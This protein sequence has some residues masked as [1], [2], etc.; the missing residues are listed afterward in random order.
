MIPPS[1]PRFAMRVE[2]AKKDRADG[3]PIPID[4]PKSMK[5]IK[6]V[7]RLLFG[8]VD[9]GAVMIAPK[10]IHRAR[11]FFL[12]L[13]K[14]HAPR[15]AVAAIA[16]KKAPYNEILVKY[17]RLFR[18]SVNR[19][20]IRVYQIRL[21]ATIINAGANSRHSIPLGMFIRPAYFCLVY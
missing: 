10:S 18:G 7:N 6:F 11:P 19:K 15:K 1:L 8:I 20:K 17:V 13:G 4:A 12:A 21:L 5:S 14:S 2:L 3:N 16:A 9:K